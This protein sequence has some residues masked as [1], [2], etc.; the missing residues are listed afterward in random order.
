[1]EK[2]QGNVPLECTE[3]GVCLLRRPN[4]VEE[5]PPLSSSSPRNKSNSGDNTDSVED[6]KSNNRNQRKEKKNAAWSS[7]AVRPLHSQQDMNTL[8]ASS[9]DTT[10]IVEFITT[11]SHKLLL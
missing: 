7:G 10:V 5:S 3:D 8:L 2:E 6:I 1:M 9:Q 11:V 4:D